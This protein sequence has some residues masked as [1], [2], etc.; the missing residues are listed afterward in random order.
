[1]A[2]GFTVHLDQRYP[3]SRE[4]DLT[5]Y[6]DVYLPARPSPLLLIFHGWHGDRR[7]SRHTAELFARDYVVVNVDMRGRGGSGGRPDVN[8]WELLDAVDA[9]DFARQA[10]ADHIS[11]PGRAYCLGGSG[12]GGNVCA[13]LGKFPDLF[14]AG[15]AL[16][17]VSD[18]AAWYRGDTVGEFRDEMDVWI[19]VHPDAAPDAYRAR[20][21]IDLL[22]NLATPLLVYHG[23]ADARVPVEMGRRYAARAQALGKPVTYIELEGV[24]HAIDH[25][26]LA[27]D[28][29]AFFQAHA[30]PP[31]LASRGRLV[32]GGYVQTRAG[33]IELPSPDAFGMVHYEIDAGGRLVVVESTPPGMQPRIV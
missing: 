9:L 8:G 12:G 14:A 22:E 18:Y 31:R 10:Y 23:D 28:I 25:A 24:G 32:V 27:A 2:P 11:N 6:A 20:S 26:A 15:A 1:M 17:G 16:C 33:R 13:L 5:L 19:G 3:S 30:E 21:G 7:S 29:H 4:R